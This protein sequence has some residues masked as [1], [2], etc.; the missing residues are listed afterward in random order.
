MRKTPNSEMRFCYASKD[1]FEKSFDEKSERI[2]STEMIEDVEKLPENIILLNSLKK[3]ELKD[4]KNIFVEYLP[5]KEKIRLKKLFQDGETI[6]SDEA[7]R[8][9]L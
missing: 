9:I 6:Y 3:S 4:L 7:V 8:E 1:V 2:L 5:L